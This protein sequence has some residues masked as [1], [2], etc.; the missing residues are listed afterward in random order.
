MTK[1]STFTRHTR[2][3]FLLM[4]S[5]MA[6]AVSVA[7]AVSVTPNYAN[8]ET[9]SLNSAINKA[10]RQRMLSQRM[11]KAYYQI[12]L[13]TRPEEATKTLEQSVRLFDAQLSE[14]TE[15]SPNHAISEG[16]TKVKAKWAPFKA[17]VTRPY[18][19]EGAAQLVELNE[20]LLRV[21][22][23]VALQLQEYSGRPTG[24]LVNIAGR[25]RMLSQ[26]LA[27]FYMLR[28]AGFEQA[29]LLENM[30]QV[31]NEFSGALTE[32]R[33]APQNTPE[34]NQRLSNVN[35]QWQLLKESLKNTNQR[36]DLSE[37][38]VLTTDKIL[39]EMDTVTAL[40]EA[41]Q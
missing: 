27:K 20:D 26:R 23:K 5:V 21:A 8:A 9:L 6:V 34:I 16:L 12:G 7:A 32:L 36:H 37:L 38:V 22:H 4:V 41:T 18:S 11:A 15:F 39:Q 1:I 17:I 19:R 40:Y 29:D 13:N 28:Q 2:H 3:F 30:D 25:E 14:L 24:R 33:G 35:V 31:Y 10:G